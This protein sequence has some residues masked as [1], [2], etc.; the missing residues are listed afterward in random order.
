[1]A[2]ENRPEDEREEGDGVKDRDDSRGF[3][4]VDN[5]GE[6]LEEEGDIEEII[7]AQVDMNEIP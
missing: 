2:V 4:A 6:Q 3:N 5:E 1:M 7:G